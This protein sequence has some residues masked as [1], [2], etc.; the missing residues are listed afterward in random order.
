M[1]RVFNHDTTSPRGPTH[2]IC[3]APWQGE[4]AKYTSQFSALA[5]EVRKKD[6]EAQVFSLVDDSFSHLTQTFAFL[7]SLVAKV[8]KRPYKMPLISK[9]LLMF[10]GLQVNILCSGW[11]E[12]CKSACSSPSF[13]FGLKLRSLD[14]TVLRFGCLVLWKVP[15]L[16]QRL[17]CGWEECPITLVGGVL[18]QH[19]V[20]LWLELIHQICILWKEKEKSTKWRF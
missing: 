3:L 16:R 10:G 15:S 18:R 6:S 4:N 19:Y 17:G 1:G 20:S 2:S 5:W 11:M 12:A 9:H 13:D 7:P 14:L 8:K